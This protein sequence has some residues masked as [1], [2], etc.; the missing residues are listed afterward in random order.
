MDFIVET[1]VIGRCLCGQV[2][3]QGAV[4]HWKE[5]IICPKCGRDCSVPPTFRERLK[6]GVSQ[7]KKWYSL[8]CWQ[9]R[10]RYGLDITL[11]MGILEAFKLPRERQQ[12]H[13]EASAITRMP[14]FEGE[15]GEKLLPPGKYWFDQSVVV[16]AANTN[17]VIARLKSI[18]D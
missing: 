3:Y 4:P 9:C 12:K 1:E 10:R 5:T 7:L 6:W 18:G 17:D 15:K 11:S 13:W 8:R 16:R 14:A 2:V